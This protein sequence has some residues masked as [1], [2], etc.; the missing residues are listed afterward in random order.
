MALFDTFDAMDAS[1]KRNTADAAEHPPVVSVK[2]PVYCQTIPAPNKCL[3]SP[4]TSS[5]STATST[6]ATS[7]SSASTSIVVV[8]V[9]GMRPL[10]IGSQHGRGAFLLDNVAGQSPQDNADAS[11][12]VLLVGWQRVDAVLPL[13]VDVSSK[14]KDAVV[15]LGKV[16]SHWRVVVVV[17]VIGSDKGQLSCGSKTHSDGNVLVLGSLGIKGGGIVVKGFPVARVLVPVEASASALGVN[18]KVLAEPR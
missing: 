1:T 16:E 15:G 12:S 7:S 10:P 3:G 11:L 17:I 18:V 4:T 5:T 2:Q 13:D 6:S 9:V 8:L 14:G